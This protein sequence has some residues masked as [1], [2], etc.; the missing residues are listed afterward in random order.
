MKATTQRKAFINARLLDPALGMDLQGAILVDGHIIADLGPSL[1]ADGIP[2]GIEVFDCA[3]KCLAP[4]LI[5]MR[6]FIGEPGTEHKE[7]LATASEAAAVGGVTTIAMMPETDPVIDNVALV[8][9]VA[10]QARET[11]QVSIL[12]T[13]AITKGLGGREMT[14]M[15]LLQSAGAVALTDGTH[16]IADSLVMRR[17]LS[18]ASN[19]DILI[20]HHAAEPSL[21]KNGC[22]NEGEV[23]TR[24]GLS[25][26]PTAAETIIVERDIRLVELT[27][28][29]YH[30]SSISTA[31]ALDAV[32]AAKQRGLP[33]TCGVSPVHFALNETSI[34]NYRTFAKLSPPLRS[35]DDRRAVVD[36]L[37]DGTIDV[38]ASCHMPQDQESKRQPF[39]QAEDGAVGLETLLPIGLELVHNG[40]LTL[41]EFLTK[42]TTRPAEL[43]GLRRGSL[44]SGTPADLTIFD[45]D[46]PWVIDAGVFRSKSK[47]T[48]FENH[49]VQGRAVMT[50]VGGN[51]VHRLDGN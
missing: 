1:F 30:V 14:E 38:I 29:R 3:G 35:E 34:G 16:T 41:S 4:G 31:T 6:V 8:E 7:T 12:P 21:T 17:V 42:V 10:R 39:E 28:A 13:A 2:D 20:M 45:P 26:I 43:L 19:F 47:N 22:M 49:P 25:G 15:G 9:F 33:V 18:Y 5:D 40:H 48:P 11:A 36:A 44:R 32:R 27:G 24:L 23:A 51:I 46:V 50:I 37:I